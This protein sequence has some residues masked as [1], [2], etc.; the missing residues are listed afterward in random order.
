V[1]VR[2]EELVGEAAALVRRSDGYWIEPGV[3]AEAVIHNGHPL[4]SPQQ[5]QSGDTLQ[6]GP[7]AMEFVD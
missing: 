7:L 6:I 2:G 1:A 5:L 3:G 4:T